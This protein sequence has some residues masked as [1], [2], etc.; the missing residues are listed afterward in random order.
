MI[1]TKERK[2]F[3]MPMGCGNY[4]QSMFFKFQ[5]LGVPKPVTEDHHG[6]VSE[7]KRKK[8]GTHQDPTL[9]WPY[10]N[11]GVGVV[12]VGATGARKFDPHSH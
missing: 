5:K 10:R 7:I 6:L 4:S 9:S 8:L 1:E 3:W 11:K 2:V 12:S